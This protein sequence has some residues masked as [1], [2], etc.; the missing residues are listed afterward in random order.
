MAGAE[1]RMRAARRA[2]ARAA[3]PAGVLGGARVEPQPGDLH[4]R[5][6]AVRVDGDPAA[7]PVLAPAQE[8]RGVQRAGEQAA[9]AQGVGDGA[10]AVVAARAEAAVAAAVDVGPADDL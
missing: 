2:P 1:A 3:L 7:G 10:R 5:V 4:V 8:A 6:A 9:S